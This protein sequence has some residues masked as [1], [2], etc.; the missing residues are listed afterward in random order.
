MFLEL[1]AADYLHACQTTQPE[2][3]SVAAGSVEGIVIRTDSDSGSNALADP[4]ELTMP[5][6]VVIGL[7]NALENSRASQLHLAND[8]PWIDVVVHTQAQLETLKGAIAAHPEAATVLVQ[9]LRQ[10]TRLSVSDALLA[11]SL[12]YSTLQHGA[13]FLHWLQNHRATPVARVAQPLLVDRSGRQLTLTFNEPRRRNAYSAAMRDA[14]CEALLL[15][16]FDD[17]VSRIVLEG[18]GEAFCAG[19]DLSEFGEARDAVTAHLS[20]TTLSAGALLHRLRD[21]VSSHVHGACIGA[22]IELPAF[23]QRIRASANSFFVLP[24]VGM[25]LVPGAGGTVSLPRRIGRQRTAW[26][27]LTGERISASMALDWGLVDELIGD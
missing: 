10:T 1:S 9:L 24:E 15:A 26:M 5:A 3:S 11:E 25:G 14:L 22:G 23:G 16:E 6:S 21:R 2:W 4:V 12:A 20:R 27:A 18:R 13:G 8:L 19:G 7:V 17:S